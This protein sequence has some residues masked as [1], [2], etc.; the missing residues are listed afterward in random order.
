LRGTGTALNRFLLFLVISA[1]V[2]LLG[3]GNGLTS[4]FSKSGRYAFVL[5][6]SA[7]S[8]EKV[9]E[10]DVTRAYAQAESDAK[11]NADKKTLKLLQDYLTA[12]KTNDGTV[13]G[14]NYVK[15][16]HNSL[17]KV[18]D[19]NIAPETAADECNQAL[20]AKVEKIIKEVN[21]KV[22]SQTETLPTKTTRTKN[23]RVHLK[24]STPQER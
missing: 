19:E 10:M 23:R 18:F 2:C 5:V 16:C 6:K 15:A 13:T 12:Y 7:E 21:Q 22:V 1:S 4:D 24:N 11:S 9:L 8:R 20:H 14:D 17:T 3:C